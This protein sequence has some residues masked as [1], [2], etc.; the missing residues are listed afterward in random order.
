M[1]HQE[2]RNPRLDQLRGIAIILVLGNHFLGLAGWIPG[3]PGVLLREWSTLGYI[4]VDIFFVLS[5]FLVARLLLKEAQRTGGIRV[6]RFLV[7]RGFKIYPSFYLFTAVSSFW[8]LQCG[9]FSWTRLVAESCFVQNYLQ[10]HWLSSAIGSGPGRVGPGIVDAA[11]WSLAVEEHFYLLVA[12]LLAFLWSRRSGRGIQALPQIF[13]LVAA[14]SLWLRW[15]Y[16]RSHLTAGFGPL[17]TYSQFRLDSLFFGCFLAYLHHS[18]PAALTAWYSRWRIGLFVACLF[19]MV[20]F[21]L[22]GRGRHPMLLLVIGP[23]LLYLCSG[24]LILACLQPGDAPVPPGRLGGTIASIG[25]YSYN[26]YLWHLTV[27]YAVGRLYEPPYGFAAI[28]IYL[29][30]SVALGAVISLL[31]EQPIL[32]WRERVTSQP[33]TVT[34]QP[35]VESKSG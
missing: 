1:S 2:P 13:A 25:R 22:V 18:R 23:T 14:G 34:Q 21:V 35:C 17:T 7:R 27:R 4:G 11:E 33:A 15:L 24:V 30:G 3:L 28:A 9:L 32:R 16:A 12:V 19:V 6:V 29:V 10:G 31:F 26:I 20:P 5:G 8:F